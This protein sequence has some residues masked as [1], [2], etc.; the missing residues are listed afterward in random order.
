[1]TQPN[2]R[3]GQT[4]EFHYEQG[5]IEFVRYLNQM[6]PGQTFED[7]LGTERKIDARNDIW[8]HRIMWHLKGWIA[9]PKLTYQMT[10]W[11]VNTTVTD[12]SLSTM[13]L[14]AATDPKSTAVAP[15]RSAPEIVTDIP[16]ATSPVAGLTPVTAG[17][18]ITT[19][20]T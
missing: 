14:V 18:G 4:E 13:K 17:T 2:E 1:M 16:P 8:A 11:T 20:V 6:P 5:I 7:H 9:L 15:V 10:L 12:V 3:S 19:G